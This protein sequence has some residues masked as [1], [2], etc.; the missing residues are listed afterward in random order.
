MLLNKQNLFK[1]S[2]VSEEQFLREYWHKKPLLIRNAFNQEDLQCLPDKTLLQKLS[3]QD[4]IQSRIVFKN[5]SKEYTVE[6]GPFNK[7][8]FNEL[9]DF[10]WNLLVSDIDKWHPKSQN[11]LKSFQFIRNWLFDDLMLSCG[12]MDG[13]V[14]PHTDNYDVFLLQSRG[15]RRWQYGPVTSNNL[16][17]DIEI[18]VLSDFKTDEEQVLNPGDVLYLPPGV[19]H[20]GEIA[21][22][23]CVTSS[24]GLR[25]PSESELLTSY[26]DYLAQKI[27]E[28][29]RFNEPLFNKQPERGEFKQKDLN[30]I[31]DIFN[32]NINLNKKSLQNWFGQ[33]ITEYRSLFYEFNDAD[34]SNHSIENDLIPNPF[35]KYCYYKKK[36]KAKLFINGIKYITSLKL[37]K[38]I[39]NEKS[40]QLSAIKQ[41][42]QK[43][44][45]VIEKLF[46]NNSLIDN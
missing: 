39:C 16:L 6:Y 14:G 22:D 40:I 25:T 44:K 37:A 30:Q 5:S 20:F 38:M 13:T 24:I 29:N 1:N 3:C 45:S 19:A 2:E 27:P 26:V 17:P 43:D 4:D 23:D 34:N 8:D 41:F 33:F 11:L 21:S 15:Q 10:C 35:S 7:S 31:T 18:K 28:N 12:N 36:N 32:N 42:N 9:D 46:K